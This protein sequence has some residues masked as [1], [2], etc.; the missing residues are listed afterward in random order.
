MRDSLDDVDVTHAAADWYKRFCKA[1]FRV[2]LFLSFLITVFSVWGANSSWLEDLETSQI[3][4]EG[5]QTKG[6]FESDSSKV[7]GDPMVRVGVESGV[8]N[9]RP[10]VSIHSMAS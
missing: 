2:L 3:N 1:S 5:V 7:D 8:L 4:K 6:S 9:R 10:L